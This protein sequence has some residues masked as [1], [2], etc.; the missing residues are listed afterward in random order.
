MTPRGSLCCELKSRSICRVPKPAEVKG[1]SNIEWVRALFG[2]KIDLRSGKEAL[3]I[4]AFALVEGVVAAFA[5]AGVHDA[6]SFLVD[7]KVIYMDPHD[8]PD[9]LPLIAR[10]AELTGVLNKPFREMHLVVGHKTEWLH[11]LIDCTITNQVML[12]AAELTMVLSSRMR[13]LQIVAGESAQQY[14]DRVRAF[15]AQQDSYQPYLQSLDRLT[16]QLVQALQTGFVTSRVS[17]EPATVQ[18]VRQSGAQVSKFRK[19]QFG[20][21]VVAPSYRAAPARR[22]AVA[23]MMANWPLVMI[24]LIQMIRRTIAIRRAIAIRRVINSSF[25][26]VR[27]TSR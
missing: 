20:S 8:V 5:D 4:G 24:G 6:M 18:L 11:T 7:Q 22:R 3:T 26:L 19:L 15:A 16:S 17:R 14:A 1:P 21:D 2:A 10:V 13:K 12:G 9:D 23:V 25:A 27:R